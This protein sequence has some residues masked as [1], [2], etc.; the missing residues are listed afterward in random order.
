MSKTEIRTEIRKVLLCAVAELRTEFQNARSE[1]H[2]PKF[3]TMNFGTEILGPK[4]DPKSGTEILGP[5]SGT[6]FSTGPNFFNG[7]TRLK[8]NSVHQKCRTEFFRIRSTKISVHTCASISVHPN[9]GLSNSSILVHANF[10]PPASPDF[11][12]RF[13]FQGFPPKNRFRFRFRFR[14]IA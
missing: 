14:K 8:Q 1:N 5:K 12:P 4:L 6:E 10:G 2:A 13:R 9:F 11:G 3:M 7:K